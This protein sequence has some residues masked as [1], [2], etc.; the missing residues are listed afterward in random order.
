MP[1]APKEKHSRVLYL[2]TNILGGSANVKVSN[3]DQTSQ[4]QDSRV[5]PR[6]QVPAGRLSKSKLF[7][8]TNIVVGNFF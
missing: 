1:E 5:N 3:M 8:A 4:S 6:L 2:P 7:C